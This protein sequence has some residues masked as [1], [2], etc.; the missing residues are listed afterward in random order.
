MQQYYFQYTF[1][2]QDGTEK[3]GHIFATDDADVV[4]QLREFGVE[5]TEIKNLSEASIGSLKQKGLLN[6]LELPTLCELMAQEILVCQG[7]IE[8]LL[9]SQSLSQSPPS[10]DRPEVSKSV[11]IVAPSFDHI[12]ESDCHNVGEGPQVDLN[13]VFDSI[14]PI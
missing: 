9:S 13:S 8:S 2:G 7:T 3:Q 10:A 14:L 12:D 6:T 11:P 4:E 1:V 5:P